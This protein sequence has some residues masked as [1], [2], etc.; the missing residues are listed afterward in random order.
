[1]SNES[2]AASKRSAACGVSKSL[3]SNQQYHQAA[4]IGENQWRK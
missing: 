2:V 1:M 3:K 4:K